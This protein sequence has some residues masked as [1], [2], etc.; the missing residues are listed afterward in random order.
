MNIALIILYAIS[1]YGLGYNT[2]KHG[3]YKPTSQQKYDVWLSLFAT[4]VQF[5]LIW[6]ALGWRF[7]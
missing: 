7:I 2:A 4:I 3:Q 5:I 1:M 6:W